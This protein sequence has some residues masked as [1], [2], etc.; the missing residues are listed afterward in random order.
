ML[1]ATLAAFQFLEYAAVL[2]RFV[3]GDIRPMQTQL[4]SLQGSAAELTEQVTA[5]SEDL[6]QMQQLQ[7]DVESTRLLYRTLFCAPAKSQCS[8]GPEAC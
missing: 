8:T 4:A 6:I 7:G 3:E 1:T 2:A 5:Q